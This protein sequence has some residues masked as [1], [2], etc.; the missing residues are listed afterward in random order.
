MT[1]I[2]VLI[3][4]VLERFV[5]YLDE[6]RQ[7]DW[8]R[9]YG[10]W[11]HR[12]VGALAEGVTG[13]VLILIG[14]ALVVWGVAGLLDDVMLG[15]LEISFGVVVLIYCLGPR[16]LH[17][18][19]EAY[20]E[21]GAVEDE[22]RLKTS[23]ERIIG[24]PPPEDRVERLR[25]VVGSI[26]VEANS[27]IFAV[28]FWFVVLGPLGAVVY[29]LSHELVN[30]AA[31]DS[32]LQRAALAWLALADWFPARLTA[33]FYALTGHFESTLPI[34]R[35]YL[36]TSLADLPA[37]NAALLRES[38]VEGVELEEALSEE[39]DTTQVSVILTTA[40]N[41]VMRTLVLAVTVLAIATL[42]GWTS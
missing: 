40:T 36:V 15:L 18:E 30:N 41:M 25:A 33:L 1:L 7:L 38:G 22:E 31:E 9:Q 13:V 17:Q 34:L 37:S 19:V 42:G 20:M 8:F 23:A 6:F 10:E 39:L 4:L 24:G 27:R 11:L 21:A 28:L 35:R 14:P 3:S 5:G 29:R 2:T 16:D 12:R 32:S 26:F